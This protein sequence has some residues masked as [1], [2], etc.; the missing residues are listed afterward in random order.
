MPLHRCLDRTMS[1]INAWAFLVRNY[2]MIVKHGCM[3]PTTVLDD[4]ASFY[5]LEVTVIMQE[6]LPRLVFMTAYSNNP[7]SL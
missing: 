4:T 3:S 2:P 6:I 7:L 1:T 5:W